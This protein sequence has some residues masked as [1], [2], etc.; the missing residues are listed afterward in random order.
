MNKRGYTSY[1]IKAI[2]LLLAL[3]VMAIVASLA[4]LIPGGVAAKASG[5]S[6][7]AEST[8][9]FDVAIGSVSYTHLT[10]PTMAVV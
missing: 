7:S 8:V 3:I 4:W 1:L 10:L 6:T 5:L 9:D 2:M